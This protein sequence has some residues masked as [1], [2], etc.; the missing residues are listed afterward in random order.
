MGQL[1]NTRSSDGAPDPDVSL[2]EVCRIK[3]RHYRNLYLNRPDPI[4]FIPLAVDTTGRMYDELIRLLFLYAHREASALDNELPEESDKF[5][6]L[7]A[8]CFT[9][10]KGSVGLIMVKTGCGCFDNGESRGRLGLGL[11]CLS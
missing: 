5:R 7:H 2:K 6:F 9:N 11:P 10:L 3:V 4:A 1:T 8:S